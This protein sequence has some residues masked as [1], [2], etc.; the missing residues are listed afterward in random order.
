[1]NQLYRKVYCAEK[2]KEEFDTGTTGR[3]DRCV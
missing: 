3:K 2:E 1:M